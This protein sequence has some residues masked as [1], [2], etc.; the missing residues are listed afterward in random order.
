MRIAS[1]AII[2]ATLLAGC[3]QSA[4]TFGK[5]YDECL[6]KNAAQ[7]EAGEICARRFERLRT[8][9]ERDAGMLVVSTALD[10]IDGAEGKELQFQ[11]TNKSTDKIARTYGVFV[12]FW[13]NERV[14]PTDHLMRGVQALQN[15]LPN[16]NVNRS[17]PIQPGQTITVALPIPPNAIIRTPGLPDTLYGPI[18]VDASIHKLV[19]MSGK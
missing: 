12:G 8:F 9:E 5:T 11:I 15:N 10:I 7:T 6:L 14:I 13:P 3:D 16:I 2:G 4:R 18:T 19:P 1:L 17:E